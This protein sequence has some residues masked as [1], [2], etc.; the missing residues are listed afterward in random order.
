MDEFNGG[1]S[2]PSYWTIDN[3]LGFSFSPS[4]MLISQSSAKSVPYV[5]SNKN[6]ISPNDSVVELGF[7][8]D[9]VG[10]FGDGFAL[11]DVNPPLNTVMT[12]PSEFTKYTIFYV[13]QNSLDP[14]L[15]IATSL[16]PLN[17]VGC[18]PNTIR[19]IY[20]TNSIDLNYHKVRF[21]RSNNSY[22]VTLDDN[23]IFNSSE[24]SRI[25][26]NIW[27]G[28]PETT[29]TSGTWSSQNV[30]Y[31]HIY[32]EKIF[33]YF[34]QT[35]PRWKDEV[36]DNASKWAG[37]DKYGIGRWGCALTSAAMVLQENG[38]KALDGSELDPSKLN[39][40]LKSQ[41]DGY[42]GLGYL[43]WLAVSRY[44]KLSFDAGHSP[45]KLEF[46]RTSSPTFPSI[47]GL[48]G[49]FVV[50]H[51]EDGDNWLIN[52][53]AKSSVTSIPK[54]TAL[55]SV[56]TFVPSMTDLSYMMF[57][58]TPE[59]NVRLSKERNKDIKINWQ[60]EQLIDPDSGVQGPVNK[61]GLISKPNNGEYELRVTNTSDKPANFDIYLYDKQGNPYIKKMTIAKK[62]N[63]KFE[64]KF[65][66]DKLSKMKIEHEK[67]YKYLWNNRKRWY[68]KIWD[69]LD[70]WEERGRD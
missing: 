30:D 12:Y 34:S 32:A 68:E 11:T 65:N 10:G 50:V 61:V 6:I 69:E 54:N 64:I 46:V 52:D 31:L 15:H 67:K 43:N 41:P 59:I 29:I 55:S 14:Y 47:L 66:K 56:N 44:V 13:W 35:D 49:H 38:V 58:T 40:W 2:D 26:T 42:V 7:K 45:T 24:T 57:G 8:Y 4:S 51:G 63:I 9:S 53:P 25:A 5:R 3:Q 19:V 27:F 20:K 39:S 16:C 70:R 36:Y 18:T 37:I 23:I 62:A 60:N 21:T 48:P 22:S 17:Q 33:P 1:F 28:H